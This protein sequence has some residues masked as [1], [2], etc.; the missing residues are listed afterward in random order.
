VKGSWRQ[1]GL[2][3]WEQRAVRSCIDVISDKTISRALALALLATALSGCADW[4]APEHPDPATQMPLLEKR[5]VELVAAERARTA[6][7]AKI[8][9]VAPELTAIARKR[10]AE[11]ARTNSFNAGDDPHTSATMLMNADEKFQGLVGENVAAQHYIAKEGIDVDAFAKRFV[12]GWTQSKPHLE[13]LSFPDYDRTGVGAA[14]N[15]DTVYVAQLFTTDLGLGEKGEKGSPDIKTVP[16]PEAGKSDS[17]K[18]PPPALRGA[19]GG[20]P[21]Q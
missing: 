6:P 1:F 9:L 11:M 13:N 5:I 20:G 16:S 7:Q 14:F 2:V 19:I 18:A 10:S 21:G 4:F 3:D 12:E 17:T 8:M 15:A